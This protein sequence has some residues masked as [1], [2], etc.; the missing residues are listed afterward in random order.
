MSKSGQNTQ[1]GI[2]AQNW[3]AL[4]LFLQFLRD[5]N[6]SYIQLEPGNS[7]DFDLVFNDGKKIICESKYRQEKFSY[8]QLKEILE[9]ING[10]KNI[11]GRDEILIVCK[12]VSDDLVSAT[13]NIRFLAF[14]EPLK[15]KFKKLGFSEELLKYLPR[16]NF[17]KLDKVE[18]SE[19][20]YSLISELLNFWVPEEDVKRFTNE[21]LQN[22]IFQKAT[23][24]SVYTRQDF[25]KDIGTFRDE[26]QAR[27]D[28]FSAKNSKIAQFSK[29]EKDI[30][31]GKSI[32]W[33][34]GSVSAFSTRWD[35][36]SFAMDRLKQRTDLDLKKW[37]D[38]WKLNKVYYF[39]FGIFDVFEKN[40]NTDKNKKYVLSYIKKY[41]KTI[42]GFYRS[43]FFD[44]SVVKI[45]T[46]IIDGEN[47]SKY[48][49]DAFLI[50]K[51]LIVFNEK[52]F[53]YLKDSGYD[54]G[55]WEKGEICKLLKK[56]YTQASAALKQKIFDLLISGFNII[57]D[58]GEF[59][60]HAPRE[61]YEI[62]RD[63]LNEDFVGRFK[64]LIG[65][66]CSGSCS[67]KLLVRT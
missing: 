15:T 33:G 7:E 25:D 46:K 36:M 21:I 41:T 29:L 28:F 43:D 53:F 57:E 23:T 11:D 31:K 45:V 63:W 40:L 14:G 12:N 38:L 5:K 32:K 18:D 65:S 3:A 48:I 58:D 49:N 4:S 16:V 20:N 51:D 26:V 8:S 47:N 50:V 24:G 27:S 44:V 39:T 17:W 67:S 34:T 64:K 2:F 1:K 52:E 56:I 54:R 37:D 59:S 62:L 60:H 22:K 30:L 10:R 61:V 9:S 19:L 55:Q 42:R 6:F 66:F 35:L 13:K